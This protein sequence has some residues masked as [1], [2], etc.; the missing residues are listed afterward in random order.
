MGQILVLVALLSAALMTDVPDKLKQLYE[1]SVATAQYV[2]T[3]GDLRSIG[4]MLDY[5]MMRRGRYPRQERFH[6]WMEL[7]FKENQLNDLGVDHWGSAYV[8]TVSND[9]KTFV[10]LSPGPDRL[11][12]TQDDL[13]ITGP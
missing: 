7:T 6:L 9:L 8:Y 12:G 2:V 5:E 13:K 11:L 3:A 1:D 4:M 10:L